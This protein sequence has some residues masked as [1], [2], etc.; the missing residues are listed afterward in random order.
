MEKK[1]TPV[2]ILDA[3]FARSDRLGATAKGIYITLLAHCLICEQQNRSVDDGV[4]SII[5]SA[6]FQNIS[7]KQLAE[8]LATLAHEGLLYKLDDGEWCLGDYKS[9]PDEG[10]VEIAKFNDLFGTRGR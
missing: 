10:M 1:T 5:M 8:A 7:E 2:L 3:F 9:L 6:E 4:L